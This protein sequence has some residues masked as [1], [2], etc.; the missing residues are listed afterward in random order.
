[1]TIF[2]TP[3]PFKGVAGIQQAN[4]VESWTKIVPKPEIIL[5]GYETGAADIAERLGLVHIWDEVE[6]LDDIPLLDSLF[7][8]AQRKAS[9][10]ALMYVN[11]DLIIVDGLM[12]AVK[13]L[14]KAFPNFVGVCRRWDISLSEPLD[15]DGDWKAEVKSLIGAGELHSDCSSDIFI[16]KKGLWALPSFAVGRPE[17][18]NWMMWKVTDVGWPLVDLTPVVTTAHGQHLYGPKQ[19]QDVRRFWRV[20]ELAQRNRQISGQGHQYCYRHVQAANCLYQMREDE[21]ARV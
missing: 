5:F 7:T 18:D 14:L 11:A 19:D 4:A 10:D 9:H 6:R 16:F 13:R 17:W 12:E 15:F 2:F 3:K 21:I 1:M 20:N 8:L